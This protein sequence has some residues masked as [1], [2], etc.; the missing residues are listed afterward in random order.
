V[1]QDEERTNFL[2]LPERLTPAQIIEELRK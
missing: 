2:E 1:Q